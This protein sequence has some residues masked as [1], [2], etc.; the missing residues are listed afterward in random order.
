MQEY[1]KIKKKIMNKTKKNAITVTAKERDY[2]HHILKT[3]WQPFGKWKQLRNNY[4]RKN[5]Q[6]LW[7]IN[8]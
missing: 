8:F 5:H 4:Y 3:G 1:A 6:V 7:C 2:L